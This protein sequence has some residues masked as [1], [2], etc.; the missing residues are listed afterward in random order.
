MHSLLVFLNRSLDR[1]N[2]LAFTL[3]QL[4]QLNRVLLFLFQHLLVHG[5]RL[6]GLL[7]QLS[8]KLFDFANLL[9]HVVEHEVCPPKYLDIGNH[10]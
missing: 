2:R 9:G 5:G 1:L 7:F 10:G 4:L 6:A 3:S 8:Y